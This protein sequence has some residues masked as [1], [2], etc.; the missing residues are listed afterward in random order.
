[1]FGENKVEIDTEK[2]YYGFPVILIGY[3]DDKFKY[4]A[5]TTS[6]SYTL[7]KTITICLKSD[8]CSTKYIKKYREFSVN[9]PCE[10][11]MAEIEICGFFSS[12]NKLQQADLPYT[13]GKYTDTPLVDECFLSIE[14][15]VRQ[16]IDDSGYTHIIGEI[17]RRIVDENLLS[18]DGKLLGEKVRTVHFVGD[19]DKRVYRFLK[20]ETASLGDFVENGTS[21]CS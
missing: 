10:N 16:I 7:G 4:N 6:S 21:S 15:E 17:K 20:D 19:S 13:I 9:L 1:M 2:L 5:T 18:E 3:K 8:S 12:H 11:L 14:C